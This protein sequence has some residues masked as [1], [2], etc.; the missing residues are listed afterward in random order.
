MR[1]DYD[2]MLVFGFFLAIEVFF[3]LKFLGTSNEG[4]ANFFFEVGVAFGLLLLL[5]SVTEKTPIPVFGDFHIRQAFPY[6]LLGIAGI[7]LIARLISQFAPGLF[8]VQVDSLLK[9]PNFAKSSLLYF[10]SRKGMPLLA[11]ANDTALSNVGDVVIWNLGVSWAEETFKLG[12][13]MVV[14]LFVIHET[15]F[16]TSKEQ[17]LYLIVGIGLVV[18]VGWTVYHS[19][20]NYSDVGDLTIAALSGVLLFGSY[21]K[22]KNILISIFTHFGWNVFASVMPNMCLIRTELCQPPALSLFGINFPGS[23]FIDLYMLALFG[24]AVVAFYFFDRQT[25]LSL[26]ERFG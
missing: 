9:M 16:V 11:T 3:L 20:Q 4:A 17:Q 13:V 23:D 10:Q 24:L 8:T 6:I 21:L 19:L 25:L 12:L 2:V 1:R 14:A 26:R 5:L 18:I 15:H 22:F 7:Y